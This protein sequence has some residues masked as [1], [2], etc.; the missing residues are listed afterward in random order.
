MRDRGA[1]TQLLSSAARP[2][3]SSSSLRQIGPRPAQGARCGRGLGELGLRLKRFSP[4]QRCSAR[5]GLL[6][7]QERAQV[8]KSFPIARLQAL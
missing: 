6:L 5:A 3:D 7:M 4:S 1:D 8:L 2:E